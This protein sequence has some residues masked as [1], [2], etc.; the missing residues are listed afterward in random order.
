M[1]KTIKFDDAKWHF[2]STPDHLSESERWNLA[3]AHIGL[4]ARWL[5]RRDWLTMDIDKSD[6]MVAEFERDVEAVGRGLMSGT[7]L[8]GRYFDY[9]LCNTDIEPAGLAFV[10]AYYGDPPK[11]YDDVTDVIEEMFETSEDKVNFSH[12]EKILNERYR[13]YEN[14][15]IA[16]E[17]PEEPPASGYFQRLF[18]QFKR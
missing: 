8:L 18:D 16:P 15:T 2:N 7:E 11:Y 13:Q 6:P 5:V 10:T 4:F 14:H 17:R 1:S 12:L 9:K 3:A